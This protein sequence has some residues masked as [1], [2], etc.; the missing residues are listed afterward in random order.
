[1]RGDDARQ[2][3]G[4]HDVTTL[5]AADSVTEPFEGPAVWW[6]LAETVRDPG[7]PALLSADGRVISRRELADHIRSV[8]N[9]L[10]DLGV[11]RDDRLGLVM[12]PGPAMAISLLGAMAAGAVAPLIPTSPFGSFLDGLERLRVSSVLVDDQPPPAL[13]DAAGRLGLPVRAIDPFALPP[14]LPRADTAPAPG[15]TDLALLLQTSGTTSRPKVVPLSHGNLRA[16]ARN[17]ARTLGLGAHDRGLS[18]MPLF[19]IHGLVGSLLTPLAAGGSVIVCDRA[20]PDRLTA[21]L[22]DLEP[23]WLTAVPTLLQG[24]LAAT[25]RRGAPRHRLRLL[26]SSS[27]SM[28]PALLH[29]LETHFGVPVIEA[30]GMTEAASQV[31]SNSLPGCGPDRKPGSVGRPAGPDV[32]V[33]GP[34]L[35]PVP[36]GDIGEVA[37]RGVNVTAGYEAADHD[38]WSANSLGQRWFRTGDEGYFDPRGRLILTGRL[39]EI[40]S[41]GGER[42]A[43]RRVDEALLEHPAVA[44]AVAFAVPHA[45]LGSDVA[46]AVVLRPGQF[47]GESELRRHAFTRLAPHEVPSRVV[48][49]D[50]LPRDASGKPKRAG[51]ADLLGDIVAAVGEPA[52]G[53]MEELIAA[54]FAEQLEQAVHCRDANFFLLG[55]DSLS[56]TRVISRLAQTL[57]LDLNPSIL[58][59]CPTVRCLA[60]QLD[61]ELDDQRGVPGNRPAAAI[62]PAEPLKGAW[63]EGCK[64][65]PASYAQS[66]LWFL[67]QLNPAL[68]AYHLPAIWRLRGPLETSALEQ[69]L[70]ALVARHPPLRSSFQHRD[71]DVLQMVHPPQPFTAVVE[72][73]HGR[74]PYAVVDTWL[75][76]ESVE[77]FDLRSGMLLR[78]RVLSVSRDEHLVLLNHHHIASDG[79][80]RAILSRDLVELYNAAL[81]GRG[82]PLSPLPVHYQDYAGWQRRRLIGERFGE[83]RDYWVGALQSLEPLHLP[84]DYPRP[85]TPTHRGATVALRVEP[86]LASA[87]ESVCREQ[88]ATLQMGLLAVV[89]LLLHRYS[90]QEDF[91]VGIPVWGRNSPDLEPV[92]G[93]FVNTLPV[94]VRIDPQESFRVLL[95]RVRSASIA[96]YRHQ[97]FPFEKMVEALGLDRDSSRNPLVQ[98]MVQLVEWSAPTLEGLT[99][100]DSE[101]LVERADAARLDLE[102]FLRR[103]DRGG[104]TGELLYATDLFTAARMERLAVHL[105]TLIESLV[106]DPG[107]AVGARSIVSDSE[108]A[109]IAS[110]ES[111]P[112]MDVPEWGAHQFFEQQVARTPDAPALL[113]RST[114]LSYAELNRRADQLAHHLIDLGVESGT[115]VAVCLERSADLVVA[116][117]AVFKAGGVYLPLDID[118]PVARREAVCR[119][120]NAVVQI[121]RDLC[122]RAFAEV[123]AAAPAVGSA[124]S[125]DPQSLA[126]LLSTSGSTGTPKTVAVPHRMLSNLIT[127]HRNDI[128]LGRPAMTLQFAAAVFDVSIQEIFTTLT[129]G[130][131]LA[132]LD[133][134]TRHDPRL[135]WKFIVDEKVERV[136][137]PYVALE[138]LA[139]AGTAAGAA[140]SVHLRD[141]ASAGEKLALTEPIHDLLLSSPNCR[142][143]NHYGPTESHVVSAHVVEESTTLQ[144]EGVSI[145]RPIGNAVVRILD[146]AGHRCP[147]GVPGELHIGGRTRARGYLN[148]PELTA[149]KFIEDPFSPRA[150]LYRSGDLASWNADG[151]LCFHGRG[152][153]QVKLRGYR[154]EPAEVEAVLMA[155]PAVAQAV[156]VVRGESAGG[157]TLIGYWVPRSAGVSLTDGELRTFLGERLPGYMIPSM[158]VAIAELPLNT[159]GK[160]DRRSLP[161]PKALYSPPRR[162]VSGS[163]VGQQ[164]RAMWA[165]V[166]GHDDFGSTDNF[167]LV[168]GHSL[169]AV[170]LATAI[171]KQWGREMP[172]AAVFARPTIE[173]QAI[174]LDVD[175]AGA[176]DPA[177]GNLVTLQPAGDL[178]PLYA[179]HGWGGKVGH[180]IDIARALG[181]RRPV[182]GVQALGP[183][184]AGEPPTVSAMAARYADQ[185]LARHTRSTP[186]HLLGHS[187]GGWYAYAV[188]AALLDRGAT[189]GAVLL[190]DTCAT[191]RIDR[192][193]GL[194]TMSMHMAPRLRHHFVR[195]IKPP[196]GESR[197]GYLKNRLRWLN[198]HLDTYLLHHRKV[199]PAWDSNADQEPD[200]DRP[201]ADFY[202][203]L[204]RAYRPPRLPVEIDVFVRPA[205]TALVTRLWRFYARG[206]AHIYPM[207]EEHNDF[208]RP[209]LMPVLAVE[210][211]KALARSESTTAGRAALA[212]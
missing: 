91:A 31:C 158:F 59:D 16:S 100:L 41:R 50:D 151:T 108:E 76:E 129:V 43:P 19:H 168:G 61:N 3:V 200:L 112:P 120:A 9:H 130:G 25:E 125:H 65:Y 139:L 62:E 53:P 83:L 105:C 103:A 137:L 77:P 30:Y 204:H 172:V 75:D 115:A 28:A 88:G 38:G 29:R 56:G 90:R 85:A 170:R 154:I 205:R 82:D 131:C 66:R 160:L 201:D 40:I 17:I 143:H 197:L 196:K 159:N 78:A 12:A 162:N 69:A 107:A 18:A 67:H 178:P 39:R 127:W 95:G 211:E 165:E 4:E 110:W 202:V 93:C 187:A 5:W 52:V 148:S 48:V 176:T 122:R 94:G 206:G 180:Y 21:L 119:D 58:F 150:G 1:M 128:R 190:L 191:A 99:D 13:V 132:L 10:L 169:S 44:Q 49:V 212:G 203:V 47:A 27:S 92:M 11:A 136:F 134:E 97:E 195:V 80:S 177:L 181:P 193:V 207:F 14:P 79:W 35:V 104:L 163:A 114:T 153:Q 45:T 74:D 179:V 87:F 198:T 126:Y 86:A 167:F 6:W 194:V 189:I 171:G 175:E 24:L 149:A 174:W 173:Q 123:W 118:W 37:I 144:P 57:S 22:E 68:T 54:A 188:A 124:V 199:E 113:F 20:D 23:T 7:E 183:D 117:L 63:P 89:S 133:E 84:T 60:A 141:I 102:F 155:H 209:E 138:Q 72:N 161:L 157:A 140:D 116:V 156:V 36:N 208:T 34:D 106:E 111:G 121:E 184:E 109:T 81:E 192:R 186:I 164:L 98:C 147:I 210:L 101:N 32:A 51:L 152:D 64:V 145:G 71:D 146:G 33:L 142:L 185:I 182:V 135:L 96:A 15:H 70:T 26:R 8:R 55:G 46:A 73:M 42:V 166:L 2:L